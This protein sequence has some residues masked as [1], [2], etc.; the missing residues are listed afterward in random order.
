M[1]SILFTSVSFC[2]PQNLFMFFFRHGLDSWP[3]DYIPSADNFFLSLLSIKP[4]K[5]HLCELLP[6]SVIQLT[7]SIYTFMEYFDHTDFL[8]AGQTE[9]TFHG[10]L[11]NLLRLVWSVIVQRLLCPFF[12]K[13][14][15]RM[16]LHYFGNPDCRTIVIFIFFLQSRIFL[17][18]YYWHSLLHHRYFYAAH[19]RWRLETSSRR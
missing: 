9:V 17:L 14:S 8:Y 15:D 7:I 5:C 13:I 11:P 4:K 10:E 2:V 18:C 19:R 6:F 12:S 3:K 16:K 1:Y